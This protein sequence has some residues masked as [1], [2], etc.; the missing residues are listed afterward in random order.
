MVCLLW[1]QLAAVSLVR[2]HHMDVT[3]LQYFYLFTVLSDSF[4]FI[5]AIQINLSICL[6]CRSVSVRPYLSIHPSF[7]YKL[8]L[9]RNDWT[10]RARFWLPS[11]SRR[12]C[13]RNSSTVKPHLPWSTCCAGRTYYA[14]VDHNIQYLLRIFCTTSL[15]PVRSAGI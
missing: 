8:V 2:C 7:C 15:S 4:E 3:N 14:S 9:H 12:C 5:G 6:S 13:Q 10:D 11:G 1:F